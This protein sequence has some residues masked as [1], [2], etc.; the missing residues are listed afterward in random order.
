MKYAKF[1]ISNYRGIS[2]SIELD[3]SKNSLMPIIGVNESGKTS[4]LEALL[5]FDKNND[6]NNKGTHLINTQNYYSPEDSSSAIVRAYIKITKKEFKELLEP[7]ISDYN[8]TNNQYN[9]PIM[10]SNSADILDL[11]GTSLDLNGFYIERE[12]PTRK[13]SSSLT[14]PPNVEVFICDLIIKNL[15]F[16]LYFDDFRDDIPEL[17]LIPA[18]KNDQNQS[19]WIPYFQ[20]VLA[21]L[22]KGYNIYE[23]RSKP[24]NVRDTI[25]RAAQKH[26]QETL[27]K[28]WNNFSVLDSKPL[29]LELKYHNSNHLEIKLIEKIDKSGFEEETFFNIKDR[30]K[31]FFWYFNFIMKL[32]FNPN[33]RY[34]NDEET[35]YLLDEPGSYLHAAAQTRLCERIKSISKKNVVIYST[36]SPYLLDPKSIPINSVAIACKKKDGQITMESIHE[37]KIS[38]KNAAFQPILHALEFIPINISYDSKNIILTEGIYDYYVFEIFKTDKSLKFFPC[39]NADSIKHHISY[40]IFLG[41]DYGAIWDMDNEG[42]KAFNSAKKSFGIN[43]SNKW[44]FYSKQDKPKVI[45]QDLIEGEDIAMIKE[46]LDLPKNSSFNKVIAEMFYSSKVSSIRNKISDETKRNIL[47]VEEEI[48]ARL[49]K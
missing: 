4:I 2:E 30:S 15:P 44:G 35:I 16:I 5:A 37:T 28:H 49:K 8:P 22:N 25:I 20:E 47:N 23:L 36:H 13:Y 39:V 17:I 3:I 18:T 29:Q 12:I 11:I 40:M 19:K 24:A 33:K 38:R 34:R 26:L 1:I 10:R 45:L 32:E 7:L 48:L 21:G 9:H 46:L 31:G 41:K 42:K 6:S 43:E 27:A 14:I